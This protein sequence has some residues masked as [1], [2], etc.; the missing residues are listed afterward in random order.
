MSTRFC[1]LILFINSRT[2]YWIEPVNL[3]RECFGR[4]L[5][6]YSSIRD[7]GLGGGGFPLYQTVISPECQ[8]HTLVVN[9]MECEPFLT[10][11]YR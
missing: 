4:S 7:P 9:G 10:A 3:Q 2:G 5:L 11:N 8:I 6:V 1:S